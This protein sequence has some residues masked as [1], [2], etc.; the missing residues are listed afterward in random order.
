M[1]RRTRVPIRI[2]HKEFPKDSTGS[3]P[4]GPFWEA[5]ELRALPPCLIRYSECPF[6]LSSFPYLWYCRIPL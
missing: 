4:N 2:H 3:S 1:A 5:L 6:G